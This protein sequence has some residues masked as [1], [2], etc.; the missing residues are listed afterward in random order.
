MGASLHQSAQQVGCSPPLDDL[1]ISEPDHV[2]RLEL[3]VPS[4]P[5][6]THERTLVP[7]PVP[8]S[9]SDAITFGN[10]ILDVHLQIREGPA[11]RPHPLLEP[12]AT[13]LLVRTGVVIDEVGCQQLVNARL[14]IAAAPS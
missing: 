14:V 1:P 10:D 12:L 6:D 13:A 4:G 3:D 8:H 2:E 9:C 7:S 11:S 5:G